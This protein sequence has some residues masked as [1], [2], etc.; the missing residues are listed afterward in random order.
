MKKHIVKLNNVCLHWTGLEMQ[1]P[2]LHHVKGVVHLHYLK[3]RFSRYFNKQRK[4][5]VPQLMKAA[6]HIM[7]RIR[8]GNI[9]WAPPLATGLRKKMGVA[10]LMQLGNPAVMHKPP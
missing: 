5:S 7:S 8:D 4:T 10:S 3:L 9:T 1:D 6:D 2:S